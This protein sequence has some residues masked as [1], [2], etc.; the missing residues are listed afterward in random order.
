[1][2]GSNSDWYFKYL[3]GIQQTETGRGWQEL[4]LQPQVR[5]MRS[6]IDKTMRS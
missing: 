3:A 6:Y 1:M 2:F 4:V 5:T